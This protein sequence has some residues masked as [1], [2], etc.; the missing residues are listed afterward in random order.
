MVTHSTVGSI[1]R[2]P[3]KYWGR[4][5]S[6]VN[7][8]RN[9]LLGLREITAFPKQNMPLYTARKNRRTQYTRM[10]RGFCCSAKDAPNRA[11]RV[12]T[13]TEFKRLLT[14]SFDPNG[15]YHYPDFLL[16]RFTCYC[17]LLGAL[18][19]VQFERFR[20]QGLQGCRT[21][22][23]RDAGGLLRPMTVATYTN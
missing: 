1:L 7:E 5:H 20:N 22:A 3:S 23:N 18:R 19:S 10:P 14:T 16:R 12:F 11:G 6:L 15:D 8:N 2:T 9:W 17:F 4:F 21:F 13:F